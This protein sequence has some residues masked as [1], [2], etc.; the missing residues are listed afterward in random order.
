MFYLQ[1]I[2]SFKFF[3]VLEAQT[4]NL[5]QLKHTL[6]SHKEKSDAIWCDNELVTDD[7]LTDQVNKAYK[8]LTSV[9]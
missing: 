7:K 2:W 4:L 9:F 5:K 3:C 8:M 1:K 6:Y